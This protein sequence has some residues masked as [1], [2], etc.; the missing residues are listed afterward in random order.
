MKITWIGHSC[1]KIEDT[2]CSIVIDPY[3]DGSVDGLSPV[4]EKANMVL[5][6]HEHG[7]HNFRDGVEIT[8]SSFN[9]F[10]IETI[11]TFHDD[12]GGK[13]RGRNKI[14]IISDGK[15]RFAHFGDL[16]CYPDN[17]DSLV[18]LDVALI[19]VGGFF[20]IDGAMAAR[21]IKKIRPRITIPMHYRDDGKGFGFDVLSTIEPFVKCFDSVSFLNE[22]S[23]DTSTVSKS[24]IIV[25]SPKALRNS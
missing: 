11:D 20:T 5:C 14:F 9:P 7:D 17:L 3:E 16:G 21:I 18:G 1:F 8:P 24:G 12:V 13:K 2:D 25:L 10:S 4:R 19:P 6:T 23:I 22:S 15:E